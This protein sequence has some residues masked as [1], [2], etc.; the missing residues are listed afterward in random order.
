MNALMKSERITKERV[1]D[2][3]PPRDPAMHKGRAGRALI[4]AGSPGMSGAAT[5]AAGAALRSG[6][7]LVYVSADED[8]WSVIQTHEPC[9]ICVK[10]PYGVVAENDGG[11]PIQLAAGAVNTVE[12]ATKGFF[13]QDTAF[14]VYDTLAIG[15]GM[16]T[17]EDAENLIGHALT[18]HDGPLVIDADALNIIAKN[19]GAYD[20]SGGKEMY[21]RAIITP[22]P[23]E[24]A[25]LLEMSVSDVED[26]RRSAAALLACEY[27]V[28]A[29]LKGHATLV[30]VPVLDSGMGTMTA[31]IYE[32][33]TGNP[34]MATGGSG[35][36]LTGV[37]A[38]FA[39]QGMSTRDATIAGVF[40]HG[41]AGDIAAEELGEYGM[42]ATDIVSA[43]PAAIL[44][45]TGVCRWTKV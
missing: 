10:R 43:L 31:E 6:A 42:I 40:V 5:L 11:K 29:A 33:T 36:V 21:P 3:L 27:G 24:A 15:P 28:I 22:H 13:G 18:A 44:R 41:L 9:A 32:N 7:G 39:A 17:G 14:G 34:G 20:L 37:I 23:G 35:D 12:K 25:R 8:I 19:R 16:G 38:A 1:T 2:L 45:L 26:D 30:A 4:V